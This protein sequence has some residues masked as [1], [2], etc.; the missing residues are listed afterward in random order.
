[1]EVFRTKPK[2]LNY[3]EGEELKL[4]YY[5]QKIPFHFHFRLQEDSKDFSQ[6]VA[7]PLMLALKRT[8]DREEELLRV[9]E[10]KDEE[11]QDY[12]SRD[13]SLINRELIIY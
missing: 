7:I 9:I 6:A 4:K 10:K 8:K 13:V 5:I 11:I 12:K 2:E 3:T 1:M